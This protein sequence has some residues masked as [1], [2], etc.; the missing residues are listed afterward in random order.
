MPYTDSDGVV[1]TSPAGPPY[2]PSKPVQFD[3][4]GKPAAGPLSAEE[5]TA[6][7]ADMLDR[8]HRILTAIVATVPSLAGYA[9]ALH[10]MRTHLDGYHE[11]MHPRDPAIAEAQAKAIDE[12]EVNRLAALKVTAARATMSAAPY[13]GAPAPMVTQA[14]VDEALKQ[15]SEA[16]IAG[17]AAAHDT[18]VAAAEADTKAR[19][20]AIADAAAA[21]DRQIELDKVATERAREVLMAGIVPVPGAPAPPPGSRTGSQQGLTPARV[22]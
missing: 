20:L 22:A 11:R 17:A 18:A 8:M 1:R 13:P 14:S 16:S 10:H 19:D 7:T 4:S 12:A 6:F 15:H 21:T 2:D 9:G 3:A 5:H